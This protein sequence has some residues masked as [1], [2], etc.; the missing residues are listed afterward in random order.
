[1]RKVV[2]VAA[3]LA[4]VACGGPPL[5]QATPK[6]DVGQ[7]VEHKAFGNIGMVIDRWCPASRARPLPVCRY[8]VRFPALQLN[9]N[10]RVF[11]SDGP[12]TYS[13][14]ALVGGLREY[15]LAAAIRAARNDSN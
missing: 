8:D 9:T 5:E 3:A 2:I 10:T 7:M 4:L 13:P 15:E 14:L 11:G 1:M 12:I 6:F